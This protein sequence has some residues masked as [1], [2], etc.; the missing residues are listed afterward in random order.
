MRIFTSIAL[1][2]LLYSAQAQVF[3]PVS[4]TFPP[5]PALE[6]GND[7]GTAIGVPIQLSATVNSG[8]PPFTFLWT[9]GGAVNNPSLQNPIAQVDSTT[10]LT[11]TVIDANGCQSSDDIIITIVPTGVDEDVSNGIR[12]Y[13]NPSDGRIS[14]S[15]LELLHGDISIE[16]YDIT[17]RQIFSEHG[18]FG[19][20]TFILDL[21]S[22]GLY[23]IHILGTGTQ[24][25]HKFVIMKSL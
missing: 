5:I 12:V 17:G 15:G 20:S 14:I 19:L 6:L 21:S 16:V 25:I 11:C 22:P 1:G 4:V 7:T 3:I 9:P 13:P 24:I 8:T 2:I 23:S 18:T 10:S